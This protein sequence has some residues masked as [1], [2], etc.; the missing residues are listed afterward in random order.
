M[1]VKK[2]S[3]SELTNNSDYSV[4]SQ[5][6]IEVTLQRMKTV[7]DGIVNSFYNKELPDWLRE[8]KSEFLSMSREVNFTDHNSKDTL[9]KTEKSE[10]AITLENIKKCKPTK[11]KL[12]AE[13]SRRGLSTKGK[14]ES[15]LT[16]LRKELNEEKKMKLEGGQR[17]ISLNEDLWNLFS[18]KLCIML[19]PSDRSKVCF[20]V[21]CETCCMWMP[22][23]STCSSVQNVLNPSFCCVKCDVNK[24]MSRIVAELK[25]Q[26]AEKKSELQIIS[27]NFDKGLFTFN[28]KDAPTLSDVIVQDND[29]SSIPS[30][31]ETVSK[32]V[33]VG[34]SKCTPNRVS[35]EPTVLEYSMNVKSKPGVSTP[36]SD[37]TNCKNMNEKLSARAKLCGMLRRDLND[38]DNELLNVSNVFHL[39]LK[40]LHKPI[41][42]F[43]STCDG[44]DGMD[45]AGIHRIPRK[46]IDSKTSQLRVNIHHD[47]IRE[48]DKSK[49]VQKSK[50]RSNPLNVN[51]AVDNNACKVTQNQLEDQQFNTSNFPSLMVVGDS[52]V[53]FTQSE[54]K[55]HKKCKRLVCIPGGGIY[56]IA[57][58]LESNL[59]FLTS[60]AYVIL[61]G[62]GNGLEYVG[63]K[64]TASV[65]RNM[66]VRVKKVA[67]SVKIAVLPIFPR[68]FNGKRYDFERKMCNNLIFKMAQEE[69]IGIIEIMKP[70][71]SISAK[72]GIHLSWKGQKE[73]G[74]SIRKWLASMAWPEYQ[75]VPYRQFNHGGTRKDLRSQG[76]KN[77]STVHTDNYPFEN[78]FEKLSN[79]RI[80]A[81]NSPKFNVPSYAQDDRLVDS[82]VERVLDKLEGVLNYKLARG[83]KTCS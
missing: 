71:D 4:V 33:V 42:T 36:I 2:S 50:H 10:T 49:P 11:M 1:A 35:E 16:R 28:S 32:D 55:M 17:D 30:N 62:G 20:T 78:D 9:A 41:D 75:D 22:V 59:H 45:V 15:L 46:H 38:K 57:N 60:D 48:E 43:D 83:L 12:C 18:S 76:V 19:D 70:W 13:L 29:H 81:I 56:K 80:H 14:R 61:Q 24:D 37:C 39:A 65:L 72:D 6:E 47:C 82:V 67:P 52:N 23:D 44:G 31:S 54:L 79:E 40:K 3:V 21:K 58:E 69:R 7:L 53:R 73:V 77:I 64:K 51:S 74:F 8:A 27:S 63:A 34:C 25:S 26:L 66:V 5:D 68:S